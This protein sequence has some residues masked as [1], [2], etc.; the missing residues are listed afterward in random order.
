MSPNTSA[1]TW[2]KSANKRGETVHVAGALG[3]KWDIIA[4]P[5]P[6]EYIVLHEGLFKDSGTQE[7]IA[8]SLS[9]I[10]SYRKKA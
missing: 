4:C 2:G 6:R 5:C 9:F 1:L 8:L 7:K 10:F 3:T